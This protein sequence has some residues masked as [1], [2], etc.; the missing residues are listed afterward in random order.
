MAL[1]NFQQKEIVVKIVY[2]GPAFSGKTTNVRK[3][4][5]QIPTRLVG[6][7]TTLD[8][9]DER[10]L[11][12]DYFPINAGAIGRYKLKLQIYSVPGQAYYRAT[13]KMVLQNSDGVVF[14]ADSQTSELEHNI[15]A[16]NDLEE[17]LRGYGVD[18]DTF[19]IVI[20]YNKRDLRNILPTDTLDQKI[21]R[22]GYPFCEGIS[23]EGKGVLEAFNG[24]VE[25]VTN[26]L[27]AEL[28]RTEQGQPLD[29][30]FFKPMT[31]EHS[32]EE[33][34]QGLVHQIADLSEHGE[35][36]L[37]DAL[38]EIGEPSGRGE[39]GRGLPEAPGRL[40]LTGIAESQPGFFVAAFKDGVTG[41]TT[42]V[43]IPR[44]QIAWLF[45]RLSQKEKEERLTAEEAR[46][47]T[48]L[49][50]ILFAWMALLTLWMLTKLL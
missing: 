10:T 30:A 32:D 50:W 14:V 44:E 35:A 22:R 20:Q 34:V 7:L 39:E 19:P 28:S 1:I 4:H 47:P 42:E 15:V 27:R 2:Y 49:M 17:Y 33:A 21:N 9:E 13:R 8:T 25:L 45:S 36:D 6:T 40:E 11:F 48:T 26:R 3:L 16:F 41:K 46:P 38:A 12:F 31:D 23:L 18:L 37:K 5:D 43:L 29:G 24:I